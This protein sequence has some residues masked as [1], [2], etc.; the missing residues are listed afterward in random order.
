MAQQ[1]L[2]FVIAQQVTGQAEVAKLINSVGALNAEMQKIRAAT[3]GMSAGFNQA[4][5][6][7]KGNTNILDAQSKALRNN[8][9]GMQQAGMQVN[10]FVTS[11]STGASPIQAFNQQIGQ[12]GFAMSMMGGRAAAVGRFLAGPWSI[13]VI[14]ASMVLGG[15]FDAMSNSDEPSDKFAGG[16]ESARDALFQYKREIAGTRNEIIALYETKL[17]GLKVDFQEAAT[18]AGRFGREAKDANK[19]MNDAINQPLWK[20]GMALWQGSEAAENYNKNADKANQINAKM[21]GLETTL[22]QMKK[23]YAREDERASARGEAAAG[24]LAREQGRETER[25]ASL[26]ERVRDYG[27][28]Y[29]SASKEIGQTSNKLA[30]FNDLVKEIGA[31]TGGQ[32][33]LAQYANEIKAIRD[34]IESEGSKKALEKLNSEIDNLLAKDLSPFEQ[35]IKGVLGALS[36]PEMSQ[37]P[38]EDYNRMQQAL[39]SAA[40]GFFDAAEGDQIKL[41]DQAMKVDNS[42]KEVEQTLL[43]II[44]R[45]G[46]LGLPVEGYIAQLERIKALNEQTDIVERNKEIQNSYE[47]VGQAVADGFRGMITGAQSFGDAMKGI[48]NSVIQE[49][50][51]LFVVQQIVGMVSGALSGAFGSGAST[52]SDIAS[53]F[54][55][56]FPG[57]AL[58]GSV[59]QNRPYL[60]GERGP[61]LFMPGRSGTVIPTQNTRATGGGSTINVSV[62]ARGAT[63]P[64]MVRQQV[65]QGIL[66]AAPSIVAAAEQR[67]ISTLRRPRLAGVL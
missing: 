20:V 49:L 59:G 50:F 39:A 26:V 41:L 54:D 35:K 58:G 44:S 60:V 40:G 34:A 5:G 32:K 18:N 33:V 52:P 64:E 27:R 67:T 61:E 63:S 19:I 43:A 55:A 1:T 21:I 4:A 22:A 30:D 48:I 16:L 62:D 65:Q 66:E 37:L 57:R 47:A 12:L 6:A 23:G 10:D 38:L 25:L 36:D 45:S 46:E 13:L 8:R 15:L 31:L 51:R 24:R 53:S 14:G 9:Q 17:A 56:T 29:L 3:G 11:V 42:F 28:T 7:I 2:D